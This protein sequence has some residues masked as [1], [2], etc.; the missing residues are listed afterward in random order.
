M[1]GI[2]RNFAEYPV[3]S[4]QLCYSLNLHGEH[5][6]ELCFIIHLRLCLH[7]WQRRDQTS[8]NSPTPLVVPLISTSFPSLPSSF[9]LCTS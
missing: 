1:W 2:N 9:S 5:D 8:S 3:R 4:T 6:R 7:S